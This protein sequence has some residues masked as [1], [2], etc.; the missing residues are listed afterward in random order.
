MLAF[1]LMCRYK[2]T[3]SPLQLKHSD[4][5]LLPGSSVTSTVSF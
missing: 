5:L 2:F 4:L 1:F 3:R